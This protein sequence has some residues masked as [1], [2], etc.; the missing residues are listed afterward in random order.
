MVN[1]VMLV[2]DRYRLT[3]QALRSLYQNTPRDQFNLTI[4][5]DGSEDFRVLKLLGSFGLFG[6]CLLSR[7]T[8]LGHVL[9]SAKNK[10]VM[11]SESYFGRGDWLYLSDNDVYFTPNWLH[12][13]SLNAVT[14]KGVALWGGQVHP[15]H[16]TS[17]G[18]SLEVLDGPSWFMSWDN[19]DRFGPLDPTAPGVCQSEEYPFCQRIRES[20]L[21]IAALDPPVVIHTGLTNTNGE[22]AP[23]YA[24]RRRAMIPNILYE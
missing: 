1:I 21:K 5:D 23:G 20:G 6:N 17:G 11:D 3:E 18:D 14:F 15:F 4:V 16:A 9:S 2:R 8:D 13:L 24:E 12:L 10:G 19:W 7:V 22:P